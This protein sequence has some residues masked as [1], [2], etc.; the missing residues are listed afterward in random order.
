MSRGKVKAVQLSRRAGPPELARDM[1]ERGYGL[2]S[3][4]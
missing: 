4:A 3:V 2:P 1:G